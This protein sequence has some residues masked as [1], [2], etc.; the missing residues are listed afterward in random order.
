MDVARST[1]GFPRVWPQITSAR[2]LYKGK[3]HKALSKKGQAYILTY[4]LLPIPPA[5]VWSST[6]CAV[7][8][9]KLLYKIKNMWFVILHKQSPSALWEVLISPWT[10]GAYKLEQWFS[11]FLMLWPLHTIPHVVI[12]NHNMV[13]IATSQT[14][15]S[16]QLWIVM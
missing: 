7:G 3:P 12:L 10:S 11:V 5:Y 14:V 9:I 6:S 1:P 15:I 16:L 4:F 8:A 13:F 2:S